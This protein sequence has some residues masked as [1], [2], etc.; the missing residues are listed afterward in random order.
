MD[1]PAGEKGNFLQL[2]EVQG[3]CTSILYFSTRSKTELQLHAAPCYK[4]SEYSE[5]YI[6]FIQQL[7]E[8]W[9]GIQLLTAVSASNHQAPLE[10]GKQVSCEDKSSWDHR[11]SVASSGCRIKSQEK[12]GEGSAIA[13]MLERERLPKRWLCFGVQT[14]G[15]VGDGAGEHGIRLKKSLLQARHLPSGA[16]GPRDSGYPAHRRSGRAT[17][18]W[19]GRVGI[20]NSMK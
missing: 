5:S 16:Q 4:C 7:E 20:C 15:F 2:Q 1:N 17:L 6:P 10:N 3:L 13:K 18:L 14:T 8:T 19:N 9:A 11:T 12:E